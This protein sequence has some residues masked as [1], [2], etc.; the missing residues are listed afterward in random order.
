MRLRVLSSG[1]SANGYILYNAS[2]A[3][4]IECGVRYSTCLKA[5]D[6]KRKN[7]V[8]ALVSHEHG[9]HAKYVEQYLEQQIPVYMTKG[10]S[11]SIKFKGISR[12]NVV[13][14]MKPMKIGN[15]TIYAFDTQHD[16]AEPCGFV[17]FHNEMGTLLFATDTYY[18]KYKF[19]GL[20]HIMIECNYDNTIL[21]KN[22]EEGVVPKVV[23][24]RVIR[25]HMSLATT[26]ST[27]KATDLHSVNKI[28]LIHLSSSNSNPDL[29]KDEIEKK[30][31][32]EVLVAEKDMDIIIDKEL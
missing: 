17:I 15:F 30:I 3:L 18:L 27:L 23:R 19:K 4:V 7:I 31:G 14:K 22:V 1:S 6:F 9:D 24:N 32:R 21:D 28:V 16:S 29:F 13:D 11:D 10:T 8:G 12:P 5:L 25:S 20:N 26:I 2:E